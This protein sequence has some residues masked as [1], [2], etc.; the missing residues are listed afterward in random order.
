MVMMINENDVLEIIGYLKTMDSRLISLHMTSE[1]ISHII[2]VSSKKIKVKKVELERLV[3][4]LKKDIIEM[5]EEVRNLQK[6]IV[7]V[8]T[9]LK[10][11]IKADDFERFKKRIDLWAP[12]TFV[13][14]KEV[15]EVLE[16]L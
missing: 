8:I 15:Y 1:E 3:D 12:E 9:F 11:S 2:D 7:Q 13:T 5:Q 4:D 16:K 10:A 14:R 6:A